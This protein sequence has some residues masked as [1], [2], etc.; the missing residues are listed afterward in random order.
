M[1]TGE[2]VIGIRKHKTKTTCCIMISLWVQA[3]GHSFVLWTPER[4]GACSPI[5]A[6]NLS[7]DHHQRLNL[8]MKT[9]EN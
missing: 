8:L 2:S 4:S 3:R 9:A 5:M 7:L 6:P 1:V